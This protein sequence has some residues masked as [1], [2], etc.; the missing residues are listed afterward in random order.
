[1]RIKGWGLQLLDEAMHIVNYGV[2]FATDL[3]PR[4]G[5]PKTLNV[6]MVSLS[7]MMVSQRMVGATTVRADGNREGRRERDREN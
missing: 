3:E 6:T 7:T 1:M 2:I 5:G 4:C